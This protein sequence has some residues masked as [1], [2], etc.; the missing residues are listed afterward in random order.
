LV[1]SLGIKVISSK[2]KEQENE[3]KELKPNEM[4]F[5]QT[6]EDVKNEET[7]ET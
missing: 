4:D 3:D 6:I 2:S 7:I 5:R 1:N